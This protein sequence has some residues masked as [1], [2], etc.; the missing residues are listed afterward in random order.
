MRES[1]DEP[2]WLLIGLGYPHKVDSVSGAYRV[3][4][5]NPPNYP[6]AAYDV[7]LRACRSAVEGAVDA[8]T[9]R[10]I[11]ARFAQRRGIL[12]PTPPGGN[13]G[14]RHESFSHVRGAPS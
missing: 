2:I 11:V 5:D 10:G 1:F 13:L 3:L 9:V 4:L 7:A 6:D 12:V 14:V 8:A